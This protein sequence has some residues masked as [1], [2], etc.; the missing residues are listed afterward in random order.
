MIAL[1]RFRRVEHRTANGTVYAYW[2]RNVMPPIPSHFFNAV[3]F[4]Y[5]STEAAHA[6]ANSGGSGFIASVGGPGYGSRPLYVVTN[7]HVAERA[8]AVRI[9][10]AVGDKIKVLETPEDGW[11]HHPDGDDVSVF[12]FTPAPERDFWYESISADTF[13]HSV[14]DE[15]SWLGP[16]EDVFLL[17]RYIDRHGR[18]VDTPMARFGH[19]AAPP[20]KVR[21]GKRGIDQLSYLVEVLSRSGYSGSPAIVFRMQ[22][23]T[24][25]MG[26]V[27]LSVG[28]PRDRHL[29]AQQ[30]MPGSPVL[31]GINWGHLHERAPVFTPGDETPYAEDSESPEKLYV[32]QNTGLAAV[33]PAWK[34]TDLLW[35]EELKQMR[36][37][38]EIALRKESARAE[39]GTTEDSADQP[40]EFQRFEDLTRKLVNV[41]KKRLDEK[42]KDES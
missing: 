18:Q 16:G 34:I 9:Q 1:P 42:R 4:L 23:V 13:M 24:P 35:S 17:G 32:K 10:A 2:S 30:G 21:N 37:E 14:D 28:E 27:R 39:W 22:L 19:I 8:R 41:P 12:P 31:L 40:G 6:G 33:V 15:K 29:S 20:V 11:W 25:F 38:E 3:V 5:E 7:R 26:G 36:E